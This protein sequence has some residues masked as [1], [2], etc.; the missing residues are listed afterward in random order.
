MARGHGARDRQAGIGM[1]GFT[2]VESFFGVGWLLM[3]VFS[4]GG[5]AGMVLAALMVV[6]GTGSAAEEQRD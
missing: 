6:A 1:G 3:L 4:F 5:V 2:M